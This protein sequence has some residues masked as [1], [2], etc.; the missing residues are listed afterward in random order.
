MR[1]LAI[2]AATAAV[3]SSLLVSCA[4]PSSS[5]CTEYDQAQ[6]N[7]EATISFAKQLKIEGKLSSE[8][9]IEVDQEAGLYSKRMRDLCVFLQQSKISYAEYESGISKANEDYRKIRELLKFTS[10]KPKQR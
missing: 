1:G 6:R 10:E 2:N 5:A 9:L 4:G 3:L 7:A 8:Q